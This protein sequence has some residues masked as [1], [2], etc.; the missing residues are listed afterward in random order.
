LA[1]TNINYLPLYGGIDRSNNAELIKQDSVFIAKATRTF[2]TREHA[3]EGYVE[4]A[5]DLYSE[6]KFDKSM[7][8]FNQAWLLN[9][10]NPYIYLG[11]GLILNK[12]QQSCEASEM[13]KLAMEKGLN[14][15]GFLAD[16]AQTT[17]VCALSNET[18][19]Q[20]AL[21]NKSNELFS[22]ATQTPN[23]T[24]QA[25]VYHSWA[26]S[27]FLQKD[28]YKSQTMIDKSKKLGGQID[29]TLEQSVKERLTDTK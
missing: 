20:T 22:L 28:F 12:K 29:A 4:R 27:Y 1:D 10:D 14:E 7:T 9:H 26:K 23:T 3:S 25:Y 16:Y 6:N 21:F 17:T 11:Y 13:F 15:S 18:E 5:F 24:L 2:G 8:H 19:L